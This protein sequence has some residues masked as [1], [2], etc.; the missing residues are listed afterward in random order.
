MLRFQTAMRQTK[1][2]TTYWT[3]LW[4]WEQLVATLFLLSVPVGVAMS[5][6]NS[7]AGRAFG[8]VTTLVVTAWVVHA[9]WCGIVVS[10]AGVGVRRMWRT[11]E[12]IVPWPAVDHF[13]VRPA[14]QGRCL[15]IAVVGTDGRSRW[16]RALIFGPKA[17]DAAAALQAELE[18]RHPGGVT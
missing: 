16:T 14:N 1:D 9:R 13:E 6:Q 2:G 11:A 4:W 10:A 15:T 3:P 7:F 17:K 8:A 18:A 5:P 12:P